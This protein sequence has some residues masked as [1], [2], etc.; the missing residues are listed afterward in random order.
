MYWFIF[1]WCEYLCSV[2]SNARKYL[3]KYMIYKFKYLVH[4]SKYVI[5]IFKHLIYI[6]KYLIQSSKKHPMSKYTPHLYKTH[7]NILES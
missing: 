7:Y 2:Y 3:Y 4:I 5:H 1:L 6:S